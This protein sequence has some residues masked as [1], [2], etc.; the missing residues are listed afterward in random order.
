MPVF[1]NKIIWREA[2]TLPFDEWSEYIT[3][4]G[5]LNFLEKTTSPDIAYAT[6]QYVRFYQDPR[7]SHGNA[8]IYLVKYLKATRI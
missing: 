6:H 1:Y 4:V 2:D 7:A 3:V 5:K 8:I